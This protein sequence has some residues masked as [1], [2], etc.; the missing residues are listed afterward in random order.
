MP[1]LQ[2]AEAAKK[3]KEK[4]EAEAKKNKVRKFVDT[5]RLFV[6]RLSPSASII[7][8]SSLHVSMLLLSRWPPT[9]QEDQEKEGAKKEA[10]ARKKVRRSL[11][12]TDA[13]YQ[14]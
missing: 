10:E 13:M 2:E 6:Y 14:I 1:C 8:S 11:F 5:T 9:P 7:A 3:A 12:C 4:K